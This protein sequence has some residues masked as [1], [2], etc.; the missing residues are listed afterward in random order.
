MIDWQI[1]AWNPVKRA[2]L[3]HCFPYI[4]LFTSYHVKY[5]D[6]FSIVKQSLHI[7]TFDS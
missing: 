7:S 4:T 2:Y 1:M 6:H 5:N 3:F